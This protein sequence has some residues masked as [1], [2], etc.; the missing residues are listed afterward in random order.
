M[1]LIWH[2]APRDPDWARLGLARLGRSGYPWPRTMRAAASLF[3]LLATLLVSV[4]SYYAWAPGHVGSATFWALTCGPYVCLAGLAIW[5]AIRDDLLSQWLS[6]HWGDFTRGIVGAAVLYAAAWSFARYAAPV[7]SPREIWLVSLYG[8]LGDP[9]QLRA[10]APLVG[11]AILLASACEEVVWRGMVTQ[12]IADR[13]GSRT[14]WLAAAA[15]YAVA[16]VPTMWSLRAG[17]GL[18]PALVAAALAVGVFC[19]AMARAF[20]GLVPGIVAHA[21]FDWAVLMMIPLW[22]GRVKL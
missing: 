14:G 16:Y 15:L 19:G 4:A 18:N 3:I 21:F 12:L 22:G 5:W 10:H 2:A 17:F 13:V 1:G 6:P 20:G 11:G 8:Q 7:G 9:Q